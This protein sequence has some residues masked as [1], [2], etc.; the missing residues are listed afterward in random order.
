MEIPCSWPLHIRSSIANELRLTHLTRSRTLLRRPSG[1]SYAPG[2][3]DFIWMF[4]NF[5]CRYFPGVLHHMARYDCSVQFASTV[6]YRMHVEYY[7]SGHVA[8]YLMS[9]CSAWSW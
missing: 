6:D 9:N 5:F 1:G 3:T 7:S 2:D 4:L 8:C